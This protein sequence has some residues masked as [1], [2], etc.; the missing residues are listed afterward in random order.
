[1]DAPVG[2]APLRTL[3]N[4]ADHGRGEPLRWSPTLASVCL[5]H[6]FPS[7]V[8]LDGPDLA[9]DGPDVLCAWVCFAG[10]RQGLP[11][12]AVKRTV[13]TVDACRMEF[14]PGAGKPPGGGASPAGGCVEA[15]TDEG[16]RWRQ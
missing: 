5:L 8:S 4:R 1:M 9:L 11:D 7:R 13:A 6:H 3:P 16:L 14:R 2:D 12:E 15:E 10:R